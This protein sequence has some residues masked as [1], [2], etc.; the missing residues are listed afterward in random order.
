MYNLGLKGGIRCGKSKCIKIFSLYLILFPNL[1]A[2]DLN[3]RVSKNQL[4]D[5]ETSELNILIILYFYLLNIILVL[6]YNI[7]YINRR[8]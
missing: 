3:V 7:N 8:K 5:T 2:I 6:D 4:T 1:N